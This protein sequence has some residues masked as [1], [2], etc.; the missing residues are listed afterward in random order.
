MSDIICV[1]N[2]RLCGTDFLEKIEEIAKAG[3]RCIILREKDLDEAAYLRLA[4][5]VTAICQQ[6]QVPCMLHSFVGCALSLDI[7]RIH[8]PLHILRSMPESE[9]RRFT[10]IG[11]SVHAPEEAA[12]AERLGAS[13]ITAGHIFETDCKKGL[14]GRGTDFLRRVC[15]AVNIPVYAIGGITPDN[16]TAIRDAGAAGACV[17][18]SLMQCEDA[19]VLLRQFRRNPL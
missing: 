12:E 8:L 14:A 13:Y 1:T 5:N 16:I 17:M 10:Q 9:K 3:P 7:G 19:E 11:V 2:R 6:Y 15:D 18:S 4:K